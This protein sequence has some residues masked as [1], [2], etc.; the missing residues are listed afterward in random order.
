MGSFFSSLAEKMQAEPTRF[1][2]WVGELYLEYH[3]G[4]LTSVAKNKRNNRLAENVLREI[5]LLAVLAHD[6]GAPWPRKQLW[7]LWQIVLLNQFHDI[8]PGSSIGAVYDDSDRDYERFFCEATAL[9]ADLASPLAADGEHLV[10]NALSR[11]RGGLVQLPPGA[12]AVSEGDTFIAG[13]EV[14]SADGTTAFAAP[15]GPVPP[16]GGRPVVLLAAAPEPR[17]TSGLS[18]SPTHLE[19]TRLRVDLNERGHI[20]S[21]VDKV[22]GRNAIAAGSP[23]NVL[24]AHRDIPIDFD[25]WDIDAS[26]EDKS[27]SIDDFLGAEVVETGPHRAAIRLRWCY[28]RSTITQVMSLEAD[29]TLIEVDNFIDWHEHQT[30]L[31]AVFPLAIRADS[32]TAEIHFGQVGRPSHRNTSWDQARFETSMHRWV[33]MSE[34]GFGVALINDCKYGYD[35]KENVVRLTLIKSPIYPW[36]DADQGEHRFR[37]AVLPHAG[38]LKVV[39][40][41]AEAFNLPLRLLPGAASHPGSPSSFLKVEGGTAYIESIKPAEEGDGVIVRLFEGLGTHQSVELHFARPWHRAARADLLEQRHAPLGENVSTL[42]LELRPFEIVT[43][44]LEDDPSGA[45]PALDAELVA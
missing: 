2:T 11:A 35:A 30:L 37:Y 16:L 45:G 32:T 4:T 10:L 33:D 36:P 9:R 31:K 24:V 3:R 7:D 26:F 43:L 14:V 28:E 19:N 39:R 21:L 5:E 18:I 25:A 15:I 41:E 29:A 8:L 13:Q 12:R 20:V 1:P 44:L 6:R 40:D 22:T 23:A 17:A 27:W 38:D 34:P 42:R